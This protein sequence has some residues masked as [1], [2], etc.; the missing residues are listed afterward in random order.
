MNVDVHFVTLNDA[1]EK[2]LEHSLLQRVPSSKQ[3]LVRDLLVLGN[4]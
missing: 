2:L 1:F 3:C 4:L